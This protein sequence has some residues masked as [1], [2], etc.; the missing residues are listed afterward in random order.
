MLTVS[1][2]MLGG[3]PGPR[4][5]TWSRGVSAL[6]GG[7]SALGGCT[8]SQ[9]G[10]CSRGVSA[11]GGCT[12]SWGVYLVLGGVPGP[13]GGVCSR[14]V[15]A[16]RGVSAL[17]GVPGPG[18]V[19]G[20]VLFPCGQTDACKLITLPQTSFA[21]SKNDIRS[22]IYRDFMFLPIPVSKN[23]ILYWHSCYKFRD[24][25][26]DTPINS[27]RMSFKVSPIFVT[28]PLPFQ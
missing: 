15:S 27:Q 23:E 17:G 1:P 4:G 25:K 19:P 14:V 16:P 10:V 22:D 5:C 6:E 24:I 13:R 3:V 18:G 12:W 21:G 20:Q 8:C 9:G 7:V 26:N 28:S 11:L 2:S